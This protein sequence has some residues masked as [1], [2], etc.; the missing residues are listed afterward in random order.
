MPEETI[1]LVAS[2]A[3]EKSEWLR[4]LSAAIARCLKKPY[5]MGSKFPPRKGTYTFTQPGPFKDATFCG[6]YR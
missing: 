1:D 5:E 2:S 4:A 6:K 3:E